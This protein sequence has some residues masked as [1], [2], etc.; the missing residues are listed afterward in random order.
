M[1]LWYDPGTMELKAVYSTTYSG[2]V[3]QDAGYAR[4][5]TA[6]RRVP[7][8]FNPGAIVD[9]SGPSPVII[10][11]APLAP[12]DPRQVRIGELTAKLADDTITDAELKEM[13]R[14]ER[15]L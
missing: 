14:L 4:L 6:G 15:G 12:P 5:E 3:W 10:T 8:D 7:R 9:V 2:T 11:P 13:L 1:E